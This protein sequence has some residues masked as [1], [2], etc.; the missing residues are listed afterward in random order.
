[1]TSSARAD[2]VAAAAALGV[3]FTAPARLAEALTHRS[4]MAAVNN[5]RLEFLGDRVLGLV[6]ADRLMT[7]WGTEDE[8]ALARRFAVLVSAAT[9]A[10]VA[11]EIGL[12]RHLVMSA[13]EEAGG[14]RNNSANLSD[15]CEALIGALYLDGG[16]PA[17]TA[18]I[19]RNWGAR[20]AAQKTPPVDAK[21]ALQEW[22]QARGLGIPKYHTVSVRGPDHRPTF[23]VAVEIAQ[24]G[25]AESEGA[26]KRRAERD[27]AARLL[28]RLRAGDG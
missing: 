9:L 13:S 11:G 7:A 19:D 27:A 21:T 24:H 10:D 6:V 17:A 22:A 3:S 4:T 26:G 15:A 12:G 23:R 2:L 18:F 25:R 5:Q 16:L 8:G 1:M 28:A 14:G 20:I